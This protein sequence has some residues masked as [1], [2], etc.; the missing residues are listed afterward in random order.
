MDS[1]RRNPTVVES[2]WV[3]TQPP[4]TRYVLRGGP[5]V[6]EAAGKALGLN[7]SN[8]AC[9]SARGDPVLSLWLG[10]D[11]QLIIG[12]VDSD[13]A[14]PLEPALRDLP[15]SLVNVSHRQTALK[16]SGPHAA[17]LLNA[18]CPLDLDLSAF[19]VGMCTRT[20]FAKAEIVLWRTSQDEFHIEVWRSFAPYVSGFLSEVARELAT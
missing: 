14:G 6:I 4:A 17:D 3:D 19:P 8:S 18:A 15:H 10:P 5:D 7:I 2:T 9:Q 16:V 12:P 11:E 1:L 13:I 20:V